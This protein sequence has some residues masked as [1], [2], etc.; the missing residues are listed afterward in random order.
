MNFKV[1]N[2]KTSMAIVTD[3]EGF[4][5]LIASH[6]AQMNGFL[7]ALESNIIRSAVADEGYW[8]SASRGLRLEKTD[9]P[10]NMTPFHNALSDSKV[11]DMEE[12][13]F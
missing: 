8:E 6:T 4:D 9:M 12:I 7:A 11:V 13:A 1:T 3:Q 2:T 10:V 5:G